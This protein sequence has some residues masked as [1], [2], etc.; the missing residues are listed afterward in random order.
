MSN[1]TEM[2]TATA[3]VP[4]DGRPFWK[5]E[6]A[7]Q[8]ATRYAK[9]LCY[10]ANRAIIPLL[11]WCNLPI[12]QDL[13]L[14]GLTGFDTIEEA[15]IES[16]KNP[17]LSDFLVKAVEEEARRQFEGFTDR[18]KSDRIKSPKDH[19]SFWA[20]SDICL[21]DIIGVLELHEHTLKPNYGAI[22]AKYTHYLTDEDMMYYERQK[23][24]CA[25][26]NDF[27]GGR[28][29]LYVFNGAF[30]FMNGEVLPSTKFNYNILKQKQQ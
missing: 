9:S 4:M 20:G 29:D 6:R 14:S 25:A 19:E 27:F 30:F 22:E 3:E 10:Y 5:E 18:I 8:A 11:G 12:T 1:K 16:A 13:V 17:G 28:A 26:L 2:N 15:F 24:A 21:N 7:I 23:N